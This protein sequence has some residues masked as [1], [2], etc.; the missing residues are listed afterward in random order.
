MTSNTVPQQ[1]FRTALPAVLLVAAIFFLNFLCRVVM[2]PLMPVVQQDLGFTHA[3]AGHLFLALAGGNAT[4]LL[5]SGFVSRA[6]NHRKTVG[7][8]AIMIGTMALAVPMAGTYTVLLAG[9]FGLGIAA[10][11][12]LPSGIASVTS[13]VRSRDWGKS[14]AVHE[15]APNLAYVV[16]PLLAEAALL[17][18]D[19]RSVFIMLGVAQVSM[20]VWFLKAGRG[21]EFPGLVP[22]PTVVATIVKRPIFWLLTLFFSLAVGSSIGPYSM[23]PLYLADSHGYS[24]ADANQ[25]LAYS[26]IMA[27]FMPFVAGWITDRWG[28]KPAI[29]MFLALTGSAL[30]LLG[31]ASGPFL[32]LAVFTAPMSTVF[33]FAPGFTMLSMSFP[34]EQR[35]I[36]VS[37][38]GPL[39]A[40]FGMG[41]IPTFLG[42]MGDLGRFDTGFLILGGTLLSG[43]LLLPI[44]PKGTAEQ[45]GS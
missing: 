30:I 11:L 34:P 17:F 29:A 13:L 1:P 19:W 44:L 25:L 18:L 3:G 39:N 23:L 36:A 45:S 40:I 9:M 26:R 33:M 21:G 37:L 41:V 6:T 22:S 5:L 32:V 28:P 4:G 12:Y 31:V 16:A 24:R 38:V 2:A 43:M 8:S 10:G 42:H 20:G 35:S 14:M 15:L 7:I 27:C